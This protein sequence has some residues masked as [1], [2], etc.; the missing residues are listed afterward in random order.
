MNTTGNNSRLV[1]TSRPPAT[2][3]RYF[4]VTVDGIFKSLV[5]ASL[6]IIAGKLG[7]M[8]SDIPGKFSPYW[9]TAGISLAAIL[10]WGY[11]VTPGIL[12]GSFIIN[13]GFFTGIPVFDPHGGLMASLLMAA[14]SMLQAVVGAYLIRLVIG[15][16]NPLGNPWSVWKFL[17]IEAVAC[18]I[19]PTIR[20]IV[21]GNFDFFGE[22]PMLY[23]LWTWWYGGFIG[24]ITFS[25]LLL[26]LN[27]AWFDAENRPRFRASEAFAI[28]AL[29]IAAVYL[30]FV[31][32]HKTVAYPYATVL[33][34]IWAAFRFGEQGVTISTV[35]ICMAATAATA[36]FRGPFVTPESGRS[37]LRLEA[38]MGTMG[39]IGLF[40]ATVVAE[41]RRALGS[42]RA[43][44]NHLEQKV[45]ERTSD[46]TE[47]NR[48]LNDAQAQAHIGSWE[49]DPATDELIWTDE[50]YRIF[51]LQ[52]EGPRIKFASYFERI[53]PDDQPRVRTT[54]QQVRQTG[55]PLM[56][57]YKILRSDG[58][59]RVIRS[60]CMARHDER[61]NLLKVTGTAQDITERAMVEERFQ[62][63]L[64]AGPDAIVIINSHGRITL[65]NEQTEKMFGYLRTELIGQNIES[66]IPAR[67]TDA[68][69]S[70][71]LNYIERP[72][73]RPM[74]SGLDLYGQ[75]K[76]GTEFPV[77]IA[78][79]PVTSTDGLLVTASIRDVTER[80]L[81]E[82]TIRKLNEELEE[83]VA[84]RTE[85][86]RATNVDLALEVSRHIETE[87]QLKQSRDLFRD[88]VENIDEV[89][90]VSD[91]RGRLTYASPN[92]TMKTGY[93]QQEIIDVSSFRR[94]HR[95]DRR[96]VVDHYQRCVEEGKPDV[97]CE[98]R[99][100]LKDGSVLW[101]EQVSRI[102]RDSSG[103]IREYRNVVRD[104][105]ERKKAEEELRL[106]NELYN[107]LLT[108]QS[109][110][111]I[112]AAITQGTKIIFANEALARIRGCTV[113]EL[114]GQSWS[115]LI[116]PE[117][118]VEMARRYEERVRRPLE[119]T[120]GEATIVSKDGRKI[121]VEYSVK[122]ILIDHEP[123]FISTVRDVTE[124]KKDEQ[125]L[126]QSR[127]RYQNL[128]E[129]SPISLWE[130]DFSEAKDFIDE[131][132]HSGVV[133]LRQY[134]VLHP[135]I[136]QHCASLVKTVEVNKST[137]DLY[138]AS[139]KQ[140]FY[141]NLRPILHESS[142]QV[143][144][145]ELIAISDGK[146]SFTSEDINLTLKG[147]P[148]NILIK[149]NVSPEDRERYSHVLVSIIDITERKKI[150][151]QLHL[152]GHAV[153]S[154][155]E[156]ISIT[157]INNRLIFV[158]EAFLAGYGYS[159]D[160]II[161]RN[162]TI[163]RSPKNPP[164]IPQTIFEQTRLG[165]WSGE[166]LNCR[167][168]GSE[169]PIYL[170]TS[171]I[172]D[173]DGAI[174][175]LI[176]VA[177]DITEIRQAEVALFQAKLQMDN[178]FERGASSPSQEAGMRRPVMPDSLQVK[179]D[180]ARDIN[181][182]VVNIR[183][184]VQRMLSFASLASHELRT[185][186]A[187]LRNEL[188][189]ALDVNATPRRLRQTL[190]S[191]YDEILR[192]NKIVEQMLTLARM[193]AGTYS[194]E[195][196]PV[197][198]RALL[199]R[200]YDE[201]LLLARQKDLSIVLRNSPE[202]IMQAD[203]SQLRQVFFNLLDNALK[204]TPTGGRI[205]MG[206][207]TDGK[208]VTIEFSNT[209]PGIDP[210]KLEHLFEPFHPGGTPSRG[211]VGTGLGL[212]LSKWI[213][214]AH[215]GCIDVE[216]MPPKGTVFRI[217]IPIDPRSQET[218]KNHL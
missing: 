30:V 40:M 91:A 211:R 74:G 218:G 195:F 69:I 61:G 207:K 122:A 48:V 166:L 104:I 13:Q 26:S 46:L 55:N 20:A 183:S 57:D 76:D 167:K 93:S 37:L 81:A 158:N 156:M 175:G 28:I 128:F 125:A 149:W 197:D 102:M 123:Q 36:K 83:R 15:R 180:L 171:Q 138:R 4:G 101:V 124:R 174:L 157:D 107:T 165:G 113:A 109:D 164:D 177:R 25:P 88:L 35:L 141:G 115:S 3:S 80:K 73:S 120:H 49:W 127:E 94:I 162:P 140:Q 43:A 209:G 199:R 204:F 129:N 5:V 130:E 21:L 100:L 135:E 114:V 67:F 12:V 29:E 187:V 87:S 18:G 62:R 155:S 134:F 39:I 56:F 173:E 8:M 84:Q 19:S 96:R 160:E 106:R 34:L 193:Q 111:G 176:G 153:Q 201:A 151:S 9:M 142:L 31:D 131:L 108:A 24:V 54:I 82:N 154:T 33:F 126:R 212:A 103:T 121:L 118:S 66:L 75:R 163:L 217:Q 70:H 172:K 89:Y 202:I 214:E 92:V 132:K 150:E 85:E 116:A 143:F 147:S 119:T 45:R 206:S 191:T 152:L 50:L 170:G 60:N 216:S 192:L 78:L 181:D 179:R 17:L 133:D 98:F 188:E 110:L 117:D 186:L 194:V 136:I 11:R 203:E 178:L 41:H 90:Y 205:R 63:L 1:D 168:D 16:D 42:L 210:K 65:A 71:R 146:T 198:L 72:Y 145:E 6:Y 53:H 190:V 200:I 10:I 184:T 182:V 68:H 64:E 95:E 208:T 51:G 86:L 22:S 99:L 159:M 52:R 215:H 58:H 27:P 139:N 196:K 189:G 169:F 47:T 105:S 32:E 97:Q 23:T 79:S 213:V 14:G 144:A 161:G 38:F 7:L 137:V 112:G 77:E 2:T 59:L 44:R 185:P 148:I